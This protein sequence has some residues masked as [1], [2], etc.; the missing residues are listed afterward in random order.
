MKKFLRW[1]RE[2][3]LMAGMVE[4]RTNGEKR[5]LNYYQNVKEIERRARGDISIDAYTNAGASMVLDDYL[6]QGAKLA[7]AYVIKGDTVEAGRHL[8]IQDLAYRVRAAQGYA[9][10]KDFRYYMTIMP[11]LQLLSPEAHQVIGD[12]ALRALNYQLRG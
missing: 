4:P 11:V 8:A 1:V 9:M 7:S 3:A 12:A 6:K 2:R 5:L 10:S